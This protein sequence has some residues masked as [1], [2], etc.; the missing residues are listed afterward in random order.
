MTKKIFENTKPDNFPYLQT[1][2]LELVDM[3]HAMHTVIKIFPEKQ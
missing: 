2:R 3:N 1:K